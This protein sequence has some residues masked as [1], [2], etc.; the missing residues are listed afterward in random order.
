MQVVINLLI[1]LLVLIASP[2]Y[3]DWQSTLEAAFPS[4]KV[5][6]S[7]DTLQDWTSNGVYSND[8]QYCG[9]GDVHTTCPRN[10]DGS[11]SRWTY[12]TNRATTI[13]F[14]T[15]SGTFA[16]GDTVTGSSSGA[17]FTVENIWHLDG[18]YYMQPTFATYVYG[19]GFQP[20]EPITNGTGATG[21]MVDWP[22]YIGFHGAD[23]TWRGEGKSLVM[24]LGNNDVSSTMSGLGAQRLGTFFG[25]GVNSKSGLENP[26]IFMMV[27]FR[28]ETPGETTGGYFDYFDGTSN[29]K[30]VS[31]F[32]FYDICSGFTGIH[33]WG[34][35]AEHAML[36]PTDKAAVTGTEY[37]LNSYVINVYGGGA[38]TPTRLFYQ[39]NL[40]TAEEVADGWTYGYPISNDRMT[41]ASTN[42]TDIDE[43]YEADDWF[44]MEVAVTRGDVDTS[45]GLLELWLYHS[46]GTLVGH[47][48]STNRTNMVQFD[49]YYNKVTLGGNVRNTLVDL[50]GTE[51]RYYID[52]VVIDGSQIASTYFTTLASYS[53][54]GEMYCTDSDSDNYYVTGSCQ[55]FES[56]PGG[57]YRLLS[58]LTAG[59]D[60]D[61]TNSLINPGSSDPCLDCNSGTACITTEINCSDS[62]DNDND[63]FVDCLDS[64]CSSDPVCQSP[65]NG[66]A[67]MDSQ[68]HCNFDNQGFMS[69]Q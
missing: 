66:R 48:T 29:Y 42:L 39:N 26:H 25:D 22:T 68:G 3:A 28:K 15:T 6:E 4:A 55:S 23:Y 56:D 46:D 32:K 38:S 18:S 41:D 1:I 64:D 12:Y 27:K 2:C 62:I 49:H 16:P 31:I 9:D 59:G 14:T 40:T 7:F 8:Y 11:I 63:T 44:G 65:T 43:L 20:G 50:V 52:D 61:D 34:T 67:L 47:W 24:N 69:F 10:A 5:V 45:N 33:Y 21:T 13:K 36:S 17:H 35:A 60:C 53:P 19:V 51:R 57:S 58:L 30:D 54:T 37:G